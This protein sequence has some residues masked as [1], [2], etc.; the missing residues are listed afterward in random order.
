MDAGVAGD[1]IRFE[2]FSTAPKPAAAV[3]SAAEPVEAMVTFARSNRTVPWRGEV[4]SLLEFAEAHG[5]TPDFSCRAGVCGTCECRLLEGEVSYD[6]EPTASVTPGSV[7][8]CIARP[9]SD[10]ITLDL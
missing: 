2:M 6:V 3:A 5:L 7:L 1:R 10:R 8:I 4:S 9:S